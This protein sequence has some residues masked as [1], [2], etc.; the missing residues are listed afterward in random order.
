MAWIWDTG[1]MVG[2][3][4]MEWREGKLQLVLESERTEQA[5]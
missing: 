3:D 4:W 2:E 5:Q 1:E